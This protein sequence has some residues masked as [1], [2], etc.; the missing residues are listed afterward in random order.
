M[1]CLRIDKRL[2]GRELAGATGLE[3]AASCVTGRQTALGESPAS[4]KSENPR[5]NTRDL[6]WAW[7]DLNHR[8][9]PYQGSVVRFYKNL[10]DRGDCRTPRKSYKAAQN[11]GFNC[12]FETNFDDGSHG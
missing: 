6:G 3:P 12:G 11:R 5:I 7:V 10:Q 1:V 4:R 9:R 8:P 2:E